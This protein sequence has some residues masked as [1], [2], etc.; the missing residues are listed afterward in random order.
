MTASQKIL[1]GHNSPLA[2][3]LGTVLLISFSEF[4]VEKEVSN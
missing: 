2:F 4:E 1:Y 3:Y